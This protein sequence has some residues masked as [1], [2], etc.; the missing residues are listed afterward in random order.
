MATPIIPIH[1]WIP[2]QYISAGNPNNNMD[3]IYETVRDTVVGNSC[4]F[5]LAIRYSDV[6]FWPLP[7]TEKYIPIPNDTSNIRLNST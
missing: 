6:D 2:K 1:C 4:I 3:E 5:R 7:A